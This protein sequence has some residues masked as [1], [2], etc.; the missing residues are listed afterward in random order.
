VREDSIGNLIGRKHGKNDD[1][2]IVL[3]GSHVD[4]VYN[5]GNFDGPLGV[6]AAVEALQTMAEQNIMPEHSIEVVAFTDEEGARFSFGMMGRRAMAGTLTNEDVVNNKDI[7]G[8][9][10]AEAMTQAGY[11]PDKISQA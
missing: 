4:S 8:I 5:G 2:P 3:T 7:D 10:I 6:L 11:N 9:S 1:A